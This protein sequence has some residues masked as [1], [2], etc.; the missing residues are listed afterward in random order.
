MS[1]EEEPD[2]PLAEILE[3]FHHRRALSEKVT[4]DD[5]REA[6][7]EHFEELCTIVDAEASIDAAMEPDVGPRYPIPFGEYTLLGELG[8]GAMGV[9]YQAVHRSLGRTVALKVLSTG[10]DTHPT[11]IARFQREA[12]ACA[13]VRHDNIVR[14]YE[15]GHHDGRHYYTME[16]LPGKSL[17]ELADAGALPEPEV[18]RPTMTEPSSETSL[19]S[20]KKVPPGRS[21]KPTIPSLL[22]QRNASI[23]DSE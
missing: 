12:R 23:P 19:A 1:K 13:Q 10:F 7:G 6:A 21:P 17:P 14:I 2:E 11:A 18:L 20:L 15:A 16:L 3:N 8:R 4:V 5:Y 9:V 22:V